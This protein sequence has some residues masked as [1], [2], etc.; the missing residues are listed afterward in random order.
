MS[1]SD[2]HD[3]IP[4]END[5]DGQLSKL[6]RELH[7]DP[8]LKSTP[9][10]IA[11]EFQRLFRSDRAWV[12]VHL[13]RW[14]KVSAVSG[15]PSFQRRA[16]V[17]QSLEKLLDL[18]GR[19][20]QPFRWSAGEP[21]NIRS[22]QLA[23]ALDHYVD[24]AHVS[25]LR[26]ELLFGPESVDR[27]QEHRSSPPIVGAVVCEWFQP[28][29]VVMDDSLWLAARQHAG[30]ALQNAVDWSYAPMAK[31]L[32]RSRRH[33]MW[34]PLMR[35]GTGIAIACGL[36]VCA[37]W[38][39]LEY[40][41][42][43]PGELQPVRRRHVYAASAGIVRHLAVSTGSEVSEGSALLELESPELEL[44]FRRAE[45]DLQTTEKRIAA[46]E[47]SRLDF[48]SSSTTTTSTN[49]LNT[50][51]GE[52]QELKQQRDNLGKQ[53]ELLSQRRNELK[54]VSP[55]QG[56]VVTWDLEHLLLRRPVARGQRLL[57]VSDT[58]GPW[59]VVLNVADDDTSDLMVALKGSQPI[60]VEFVIVSAPDRIHQTT[61]RSV[62]E[63]VEIR[64]ADEQPTLL[65]LADVPDGL[66]EAVVAGVS[67][68]GRIH[69]GRRPAAFIMFGK[70]FRNLREHLLFPWG[71]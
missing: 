13:G 52:L 24:E 68:R 37:G 33:G 12:L 2:N 19:S 1:S 69:C 49:Q 58:S 70:L 27:L 67:V 41:V 51:S 14:W 48:G 35:W 18:I 22:P 28:M 4:S 43:A 7:I 21:A 47:A 9:T 8:D 25:H 20:K 31:L 29:P 66:S 54:V 6:F 42:E 50:L 65:C 55:I 10:I 36:L 46:I 71:W 30:I 59:E 17:V 44:E 45:G 23:Q 39:P 56:Q 63:T 3:P 34:Q 5:F 38:I 57:S 32:R 62:S 26:V 11:T 40:T 16:A 15:I 60:R 61:V 64:S 53:L